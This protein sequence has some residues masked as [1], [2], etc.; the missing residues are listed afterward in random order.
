[1]PFVQVSMR[2]TEYTS[3]GELQIQNKELLTN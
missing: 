2:Q 1:M 3:K